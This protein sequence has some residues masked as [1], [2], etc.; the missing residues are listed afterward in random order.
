MTSIFSLPHDI[1][2]SWSFWWEVR[3]SEIQ[4]EL[5]PWGK[6]FQKFCGDFP[7]SGS[8][9]IQGG[10]RPQGRYETTQYICIF[11]IIKKAFHNFF[12]SNYPVKTKP[13]IKLQCWDNLPKISKISIIIIFNWV[14]TLNTLETECSN[15]LLFLEKITISLM[16]HVTVSCLV[17]CLKVVIYSMWWLLAECVWKLTALYTTFHHLLMSTIKVNNKWYLIRLPFTDHSFY[18]L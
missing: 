18:W 12:H 16:M 10:D 15:V 9:K 5:T 8:R 13:T 17:E 4:G 11:S 14:W 7:Q 6:Q 2:L 1:V 3:F